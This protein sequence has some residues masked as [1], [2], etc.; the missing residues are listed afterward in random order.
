LA[1]LIIS[2][3][4]LDDIRRGGGEIQTLRLYTALHNLNSDVFVLSGRAWLKLPSKG[5][6]KVDTKCVPVTWIPKPK[7][8]TFGSVI[9]V[10]CVLCVFIQRLLYRD[11]V[12]I[13]SIGNIAALVCFL[14]KWTGNRVVC[15][16]MGSDLVELTNLDQNMI[17][18]LHHSMLLSIDELIVQN[19]EMCVQAESLGFSPKKIVH[20]QNG[21]DTE[22]FHPANEAR[23]E[24]RHRLGLPLQGQII[25]CTNRLH[26]LKRT[27]DVLDALTL[28]A[29]QSV[30]C[31]LVLLGDGSE[32]INLARQAISSGLTNKVLFRGTVTNVRDYLQAVDVFVLASNREAHSNAVLEAMSC[33]L[34]VVVSQTYGNQQ[35]IRHCYDGCLVPVGNPQELADVL[36]QIL[37]KPDLA[38]A[39]GKNARQTIEE[40]YSVNRMVEHYMQIYSMR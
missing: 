5:F 30:D 13:L 21:V 39:L 16:A 14:A 19:H 38:Q 8:Q 37:S 36:E 12:H 9:F 40:K 18:K 15:R 35:T 11:V 27:E 31:Y 1:I 34:P 32:R 33:G 20:I 24:L 3:E 10:L 2:M 7:I 6:A 29:K 25:C 22:Y 26:P 28:L 4:D 23:S 17:A